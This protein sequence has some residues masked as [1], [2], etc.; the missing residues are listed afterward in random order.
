MLTLFLERNC[1]RAKLLP[2]ARNKKVAKQ[3]WKVAMDMC[4]LTEDRITNNK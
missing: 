4:H 1:R 2:N 3:L